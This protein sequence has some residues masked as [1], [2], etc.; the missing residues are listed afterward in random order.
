M[1]LLV[2]LVAPEVMRLIGLTDAQTEQVADAIATACA[3]SAAT[4]LP[5]ADRLDQLARLLR[6]A[7]APR[8]VT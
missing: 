4:V 8:D 3:R 6:A 2:R 7:V 1:T 5:L